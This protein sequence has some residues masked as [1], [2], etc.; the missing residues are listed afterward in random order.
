MHSFTLDAQATTSAALGKDWIAKL[1]LG[2]TWVWAQC[3]AA[4]ETSNSVFAL[5]VADNNH[6][7]GFADGGLRIE[8]AV[9]SNSRLSRFLDLGVRWQLQAQSEQAV[10]GFADQPVTMLARGVRRTPLSIL[11]SSGGTYRVTPAG[12]LF[13]AGS[14]QATQSG[15]SANVTGGVRVQF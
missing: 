2:T 10:G 12:A 1:H 11:V 8:T 9:I 6:T 14:G 5:T 13:A 4:D 7:A 3:A 15:N